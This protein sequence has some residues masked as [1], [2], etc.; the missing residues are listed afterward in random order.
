MSPQAK[1]RA[2]RPILVLALPLCAAACTISHGPTP[3]T[4]LLSNRNLPATGVETVVT[5]NPDCGARGPG[6]VAGSSFILPPDATRIIAARPGADV[7]WRR[8]RQPSWPGWNRAFLAPG[9]TI[10]STL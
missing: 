4:L 7:C 2:M 10:D 3:G 6:F 1:R 5:A 9:R 8:A